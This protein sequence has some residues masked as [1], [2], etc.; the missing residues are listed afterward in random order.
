MKLIIRKI[1]IVTGSHLCHNPRVVKEATALQASGYDVEVLGGWFD[2]ALKA[3]DQELMTKVKFRYR[4]LHDLTEQAALRFW[5]R[6]RGRLAK[7]FHTRAGCEN[8]WQLGYFVSALRRAVRCSKADLLIAHSEPAL[9]A[10]A[11]AG[12]RDSEVGSH[13]GLDMEDWFSED[14]PPE[15]RRERPVKL[16]RKIEQKVLGS[17][18]HTTCTSRAMSEALAS[19]YGCRPPAV[20]Y[21][22]FPWSDRTF[23]DG[24][25]K[26]RRNLSL[27]SIHW[28]SQ[29]LGHARGLKE[30]VEAL[31]QVPYAAEIH[32]R[33]KPMRGFDEWL[34]GRLPES[35]RAR[36]F[37][38][39]LVS[40]DELL[41]R[42]AEHDIGF[43]GEE[44]YC[45]NRDLTI[46]N[47]ILHYLLGGLAVIAS[48]TA[49]H[50]EVA[51]QAVGAVRL[52]ASGNPSALAQELNSLLANPE[53]L[54]GT[55]AAALSA[56][57]RTF[58]WEKAAPVLIGS[59]RA[60]LADKRSSPAQNI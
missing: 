11:E 6:A 21:N 32:L 13:V 3:R 55:K 48:D 1:L 7:A 52:Y 12:G 14:L 33:G 47:K 36:L 18:G 45:R 35:W 50:Q 44:K 15:D 34:A 9:W 28:Y 27:P 19:E 24:E 59:V 41:S 30:L 40:N 4:A 20:V 57:E 39:D 29:T 60:G 42:I 16:L 46:T 54:C 58:C 31:P 49:G 26:D 37:V 10:V 38:H 43:A 22:A 2:P 23:L 8:H 25:F 53:L 56:A 51:R 5:L 17:A